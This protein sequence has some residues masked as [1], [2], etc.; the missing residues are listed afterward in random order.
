[1]CL[2][3]LLRSNPLA[4]RN[5]DSRANCGGHVLVKALEIPEQSKQWSSNIGCQTRIT[6]LPSQVFYSLRDHCTGN[7]E[8]KKA[9]FVNKV[10]EIL[11][12]RC[13]V[14]GRVAKP[15]RSAGTSLCTRMRKRR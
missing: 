9:T 12:G 10:N 8:H 6:D 13:Y 4:M 5:A 3:K 2:A 15:G 14:N 7:L 11:K 1:L